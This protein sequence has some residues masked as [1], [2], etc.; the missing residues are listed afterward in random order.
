M[1]IGSIAGYSISGSSTISSSLTEVEERGGITS[2]EEEGGRM[3]M[4]ATEAEDTNGEEV[5]K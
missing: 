3:E 5:R 2:E 1:M 4:A